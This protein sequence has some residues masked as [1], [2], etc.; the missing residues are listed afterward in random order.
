MNYFSKDEKLAVTQ[1]ANRVASSPGG[2]WRDWDFRQILDP[3]RKT[4]AYDD[5]Y[6]HRLPHHRAGRSVI[7]RIDD[8]EKFVLFRELLRDFPPFIT[9][10]NYG[11]SIPGDVECG[12]INA[13]E[14]ASCEVGITCSR[15]FGWQNMPTPS[16][17]MAKRIGLLKMVC[18]ESGV[19][20]E[21][22][23]NWEYEEGQTKVMKILYLHN[24]NAIAP[25]KV[26]SFVSRMMEVLIDRCG[27]DFVCGHPATTETP[28]HPNNSATEK[29]FKKWGEFHLRVDDR[30]EEFSI[31]RLAR[32]WQ[33]NGQ[34][35]I[36]PSPEN[37]GCLALAY[38]S[39]KF[40]DQLHETDPSVW[41]QVKDINEALASKVDLRSTRVYS[42]LIN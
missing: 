3:D 6:F 31:S 9:V 34:F 41:K 23:D 19:F 25:A 26:R 29:R 42:S 37:D 21:L 24:P 12:W 32:Y 16:K 8:Y 1:L 4:F 40:N 20:G 22:M 18:V 11:G 7:R 13:I 5:T 39:D 30:V 15:G 14:N 27:Y 38:W 2:E 10:E 17:R 36:I 28:E 35:Q 33:I